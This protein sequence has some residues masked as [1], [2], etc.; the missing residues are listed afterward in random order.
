MNYWI[1]TISRDHVLRGVA[2]GFTQANHGQ[3]AGVARLNKG[4]WMVFYSPKS[5]F[6]DGE[7]LQAFTAICQITDNEPYQVQIDGREPWRR[8]VDFKRCKETPIKPLIGELGFITDKTHWGYRFRFGL[9][10]IP[11]ADFNLIKSAMI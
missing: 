3:R 1:N 11:E 8:N 9:F 7:P 10:Q 2:A 4:D 5:K 6:I